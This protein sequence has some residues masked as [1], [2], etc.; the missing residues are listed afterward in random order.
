MRAS[1]HRPV[2][3]CTSER[4][5]GSTR[6]STSSSIVSYSVRSPGLR[7]EGLREPEGLCEVL[8]ERRDFVVAASNATPASTS[9]AA[10]RKVLVAL[11]R[12]PAARRAC[13]IDGGPQPAQ[14]AVHVE[15]DLRIEAFGRIRRDGGIRPAKGSITIVLSTSR[16]RAS[17]GGGKEHIVRMARILQQGDQLRGR[18]I[19][20]TPRARG[21]SARDARSR[22]PPTGASCTWHS[23]PVS[24]VSCSAP[25]W[26]YGPCSKPTSQNS[27]GRSA[28]AI[29]NSSTVWPSPTAGGQCC[30]LPRRSG[31]NRSTA[32]IPVGT[33]G[34]TRRSGR[35]RG[36]MRARASRPGCGR[37]RRSRS[38]SAPASSSRGTRSW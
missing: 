31:A 10:D 2:V 14:R 24:R 20:G 36:P 38:G 15:R 7:R 13:G 18:M 33:N 17:V 4:H 34:M 28:S 37:G 6:A 16:S 12:V 21:R 9:R 30:T 1:C 5:R 11:A 27:A 23:T 35:R 32:R 3:E 29:A 22:R 8:C 19:A 25:A 26:L